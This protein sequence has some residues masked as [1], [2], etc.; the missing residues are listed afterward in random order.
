MTT[1]EPTGEQIALRMAAEHKWKTFYAHAAILDVTT[2]DWHF[3]TSGPAPVW[4]MQVFGPD[5]AELLTRFAD[6]I[7][8]LAPRLGFDL[9]GRVACVWRAG[10][11]WLEVWHLDTA[12][13]P[14]SPPQPLPAPE[15]PSEDKPRGL[16]GGRLPFPRR[17]KTPK[18]TPAA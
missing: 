18:E 10:G 3:D 1:P 6:S 12:S 9:P 16:L 15:S 5:Q 13:V 8:D 17:T 14:H 4:S 11:V 2:C 7:A